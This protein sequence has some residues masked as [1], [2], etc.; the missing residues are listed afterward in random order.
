MKAI[1]VILLVLSISFTSVAQNADAILGK[2]MTLSGNCLVEVYKQNTEFKAKLLWF[3]EGNKP[4]N[5]WTDEK[6]HDPALRNRKLLGM[7]VLRGLHYDPKDNEW[8]DGIIYDASS[9]KEWDSEVW[10]TDQNLLKV[11]GYWLFKFLSQTK[12]FKKV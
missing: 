8:V 2:W 1:T 6:N 4:L 7:D 10:L 3:K 12:T 5:D 9:G 11:K